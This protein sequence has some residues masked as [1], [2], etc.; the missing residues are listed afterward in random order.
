MLTQEEWEYMKM[1]KSV[2]FVKRSLKVSMLKIKKFQKLE[3]HCH[4]AG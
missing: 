3:D 4:Y 1:Q 2:K